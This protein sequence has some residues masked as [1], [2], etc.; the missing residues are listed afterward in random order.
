MRWESKRRNARGVSTGWW[1]EERN[2]RKD[3]NLA[4][5]ENRSRSFRSCSK[6]RHNAHMSCPKSQVIIYHDVDRS[7]CHKRLTASRSRPEKQWRLLVF[8]ST[9]SYG[10]SGGDAVYP[11]HA[12]SKWRATLCR[13]QAKST[14]AIDLHIRYHFPALPPSLEV[15]N[16]DEFSRE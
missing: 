8:A 15:I 3:L 5:K 10:T 13:E 11:V 4:R 14:L 2:K 16:V 1:I 12:S 6:Q 9:G 7:I